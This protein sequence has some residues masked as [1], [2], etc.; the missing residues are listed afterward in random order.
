MQPNPTHRTLIVARL[1]P[2]RQAQVAEAFAES[3]QT[4][5]PELVGVEARTLFTFHDLYFH[6]IESRQDPRTT[7]PAVREHPGWR[8]INERLA[9]HVR[10]YRPDWSGPADAMARPFY[11]WSSR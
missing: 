5:L 6:L 9:A 4:E 8:D 2:G 7:L 10:P 11:H 1:E 3:D